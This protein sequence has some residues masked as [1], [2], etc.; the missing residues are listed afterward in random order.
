MDN[1]LFL[2]NAALNYLLEKEG[3]KTRHLD[4]LIISYLEC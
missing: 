1:D 3:S 4:V 2:L